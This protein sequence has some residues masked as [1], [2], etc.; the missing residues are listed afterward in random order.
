MHRFPFMGSKITGFVTP[1]ARITDP[2]SGST[3]WKHE[4]LWFRSQQFEIIRDGSRRVFC[5]H[6]SLSV[7]K[8]FRLPAR[9]SGQI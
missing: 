8:F 7:D 9:V 2:Q 3:I 4:S 6:A 5:T 1:A